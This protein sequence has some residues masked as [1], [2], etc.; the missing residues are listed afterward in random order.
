MPDFR[1]PIPYSA[2]GTLSGVFPT[3]FGITM[4]PDGNEIV[5]IYDRH[6]TLYENTIE[7]PVSCVIIVC[8][9]VFGFSIRISSSHLTTNAS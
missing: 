3:I 7:N 6:L 5:M 2:E 4:D 8:V 9:D 1:N